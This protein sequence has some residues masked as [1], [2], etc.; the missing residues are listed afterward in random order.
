MTN[1]VLLVI[2]FSHYLSVTSALFCY[3]N[4][5]LD[6]NDPMGVLEECRRGYS[7]VRYVELKDGKARKDAI[8]C[9]F[10]DNCQRKGERRRRKEPDLEFYCI[11]CR[12]DRCV[13]KSPSDNRKRTTTNAPE[14][15][16]KPKREAPRDKAMM[17]RVF[18]KPIYLILFFLLISIE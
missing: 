16:E 3:H 8:Q 12:E 9:D 4:Q 11:T 2:L 18:S 6:F 17:L 7:C 15:T 14:P 5:Y 13:P 1:S 10:L